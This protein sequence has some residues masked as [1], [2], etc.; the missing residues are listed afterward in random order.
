VV[1]LLRQLPNL[2]SAARFAASPVLLALAWTGQ[3]QAFGWVLVVAL[4]SDA[5]DGW[6]ARRLNL[7][8]RLGTLLD[9]IADAL[10]LAS[11]VVGAVVFFPDDLARHGVLIGLTLGLILLHYAVSLW[12]YSRPAAFHTHL[13]RAT[14][15]AFAAFLVVL[16][17]WG[18]VDWL[19]Y[20]VAA[21]ALLDLAEEFVLLWLLPSWTP[22]VGGLW[23]VLR[24]RQVGGAG[25]SGG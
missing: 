16:F 8:S 13:G 24:I 10:L 2:I 21:L 14:A 23:R 19:F 22:D 25:P 18:F 12:R 11:V 4:A 15:V 20:V 17:L 1:L 5:I 9:S 6:L 7:V 3:R